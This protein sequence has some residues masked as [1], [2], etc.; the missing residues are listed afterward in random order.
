M[1]ILLFSLDSTIT[2]D[3]LSK[4]ETS[5]AGGLEKAGVIIA[6]GSVF[7]ASVETNRK[8]VLSESS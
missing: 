4:K 1:S 6:P 2:V 3:A 7:C 8:T 5:T